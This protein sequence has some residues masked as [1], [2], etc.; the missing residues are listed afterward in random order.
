[1]GDDAARA[2]ALGRMT[3]AYTLGATMGPYL[4][5]RL[6]EHGDLYVGAKVAT[7]G[8]LLSV[9][10]SMAFLP[11]ATTAASERSKRSKS[12]EPLTPAAVSGQQKQ[13]IFIDEAED[14]QSLIVRLDRQLSLAGHLGH[15]ISLAVRSSLWP[16]L[17]VKVVGGI[18]A[19]MHS[20]VVPLVL[21]QV[22]NYDPTAL[23]FSMSSV[24]F[25]VA[26]FAA[27]L[28]APLISFL[29]AP[30]VSKMGLMC[31][32]VLAI[33]LAAIVSVGDSPETYLTVQAQVL[34]TNVL[35]GI[36]SHALATSVT[37]LTT[38]QVER[39]EQ[40][41]LLGLEHGFFSLARIVG[42]PLGTRL[43][44]TSQNGFWSVAMCCGCIDIA[45]I[46]LMISSV[47][48]P[49]EHDAGMSSTS[50]KRKSN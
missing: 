11:D 41:A 23:G 5:G 24:N 32:S 26:A 47:A 45:L 6:A 48:R 37:T 13:R 33:I 40:G 28:I 30:G 15:A 20:T 2:R 3:T 42:P 25:G 7:I 29:T 9:A 1:M 19:S 44:A 46:A 50:T 38:G 12:L 34:S 8:S 21:T 35:H 22:L 31:R 36:A 4:G 14:H 17:V 27:F 39:D 16:L 10:L 18:S 49:S 43:L